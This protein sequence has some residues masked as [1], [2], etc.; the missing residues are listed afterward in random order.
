MKQRCRRQ[1]RW[2]AAACSGVGGLCARAVA[3]VQAPQGHGVSHKQARLL[4]SSLDGDVVE[5][6]LADVAAARAEHRDVVDCLRAV[7]ARARLPR[8]ACV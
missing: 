8:D 2:R 5:A 7:K 4:E 3:A 1:Q 6:V